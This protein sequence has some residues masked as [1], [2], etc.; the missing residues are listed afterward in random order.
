MVKKNLKAIVA[1]LV[2][3]IA[4]LGNH[5]GWFQMNEDIQLKLTD[6]VIWLLGGGVSGA[7]VWFTRNKEG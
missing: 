6:V 5:M 1:A 4:L 2:T 3:L 7:L